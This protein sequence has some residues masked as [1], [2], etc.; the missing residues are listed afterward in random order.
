MP[1]PLPRIFFT[2]FYRFYSVQPTVSLKKP[3][4]ENEKWVPKTFESDGKTYIPDPKY[5]NLTENTVKLMQRRLLFEDGNPLNLLKRRIVNHFYKKHRKIGKGV[6]KGEVALLPAP[7]LF[8]NSFTAILGSTSP[9]FTVCEDM[10]RVVTTFENF[11]SLLTPED[12]VSRKLSDS[13]YVN[14]DHCLRAHTS[15]HQ[16][17]LMKQGLDNFLVIGDV[18]RRDEVDKSHYPCFHQMEGEEN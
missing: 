17:G 12:H 13:Y 16:F 9:L 15:A 4:P 8:K 14:E 11:D 3:L 2:N 10:H 7:S 1:R 6:E 5:F 18:Y